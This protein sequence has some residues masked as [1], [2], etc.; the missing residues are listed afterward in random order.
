MYFL[1]QDTYSRHHMSSSENTQGA[2]QQ[3]QQQQQVFRLGQMDTGL[4][5]APAVKRLT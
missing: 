1:F 5:V 3:Q 2:Q 4:T